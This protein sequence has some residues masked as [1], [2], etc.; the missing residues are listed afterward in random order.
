MP[1][2]GSIIT[3]IEAI[4]ILT[5]ATAYQIA[6]GGIRGAEGSVRLHITGT[7]DQIKNVQKILSE[8]KG[9]PPY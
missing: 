5:G 3:E 1:M 7:P 9:E 4:N 6:A 2:T 8:I